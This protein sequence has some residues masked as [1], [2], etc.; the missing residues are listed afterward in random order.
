MEK[1]NTVMTG[2]I[3]LSFFPEIV[4]KSLCAPECI[5]DSMLLK[6]ILNQV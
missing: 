5:G 3:I 1:V 4:E 2:L 6:L